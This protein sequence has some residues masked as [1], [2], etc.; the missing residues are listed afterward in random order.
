M[1]EAVGGLQ[2]ALQALQ[3]LQAQQQQQ[4]QHQQQ[5]QQQQQ[6]QLQQPQPQ[7]AQP[8][9][10]QPQQQQQQLG[11]EDEDLL[12]PPSL[13]QGSDE[14]DASG[15]AVMKVKPVLDPRLF[16]YT[17]CWMWYP[18]SLYQHLVERTELGPSPWEHPWPEA[19]TAMQNAVDAVTAAF[20]VDPRDPHQISDEARHRWQVAKEWCHGCAQSQYSIYAAAKHLPGTRAAADKRWFC[21]ACLKQLPLL[22]K[23]DAVALEQSN[24]LCGATSRV[25]S[26]ASLPHWARHM[27]VLSNLI[28]CERPNAACTVAAAQHARD[29][30][31]RVRLQLLSMTG[32]ERKA[33]DQRS[34]EDIDRLVRESHQRYLQKTAQERQDGLKKKRDEM[35]DRRGGLKGGQLAVLPACNRSFVCALCRAVVP[36]RDALRS[37]V[38]RQHPGKPVEQTRFKGRITTADGRWQYGFCVCTHGAQCDA[39]ACDLVV[40]QWVRDPAAQAW[41]AALELV[42]PQ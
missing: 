33:L 4:Q 15:G 18:A 16:F 20:G 40:D 1:V 13:E 22:E 3:A 31:Q 8:Q 36:S 42:V 32:N 11:D 37:H 10:P 30:M 19:F 29:Q 34:I 9:L 21:K 38:R 28:H 25:D 26:T 5:Q 39:V 17:A 6:Q 41:Q 27:T 7:P 23:W 14:M 2:A 24:S 12:P 35:R